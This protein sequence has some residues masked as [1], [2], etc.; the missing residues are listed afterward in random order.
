MRIGLVA[1]KKAQTTRRKVMYPYVN[2][3]EAPPSRTTGL[4]AKKNH[5]VILLVRMQHPKEANKEEEKGAKRQLSWEERALAVDFRP[6]IP[7]RGTNRD[8][9]WMCWMRKR[10]GHAETGKEAG[11]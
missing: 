8:L 11:A 2:E 7:A 5:F 6:L 9:G 3:D 4:S 10:I 1:R